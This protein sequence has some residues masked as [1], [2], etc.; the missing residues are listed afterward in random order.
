[1]KCIQC[2]THRLFGSQISP[3]F[4][5]EVDL[6]PSLA[7]SATKKIN[8]NSVISSTFLPFAKWMPKSATYYSVCTDFMVKWAGLGDETTSVSENG[9][10]KYT[11][12]KRCQ[13]T[14]L[15]NMLAF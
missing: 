7:L 3:V 5:G 1:M 14:E 8:A 4:P 9:E 10:M 15:F 6:T 11:I 13:Q 12:I 2:T